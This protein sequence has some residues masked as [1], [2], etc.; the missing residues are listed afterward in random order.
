MVRAFRSGAIRAVELEV[1]DESDASGF[2][3]ICDTQDECHE[4]RH[5]E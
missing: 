5:N 3:G 2:R 4:K 1:E